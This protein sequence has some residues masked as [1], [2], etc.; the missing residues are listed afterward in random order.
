MV[1]YSSPTEDQASQNPG[2]DEVDDPQA[3]FYAK[4]LLVVSVC[5]RWE[6]HC[7]LRVWPLGAHSHSRRGLYTMHICT[8]LCYLDLVGYNNKRHK[9]WRGRVGE[10][11]KERHR[12]GYDHILSAC[13]NKENLKIKISSQFETTVLF[14]RLNNEQRF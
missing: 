11:K 13:M 12:G 2:V 9:F 3:Q 5:S 8:V 4:E 10:G 6:T 7:L 1:A 14:R